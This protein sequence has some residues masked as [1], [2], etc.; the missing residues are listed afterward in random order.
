MTLTAD[1]MRQAAVAA[2]VLNVSGGVLAAWMM[3][4]ELEGGD[5]S[6]QL[7]L[8]VLVAGLIR[9]GYHDPHVAVDERHGAYTTVAVPHRMRNVWVPPYPGK[10]TWTLVRSTALALTPQP[11]EILP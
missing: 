11:S 9:D 5:S 6:E 4:V 8:A 1:S 7:G 2:G 3:L 10:T